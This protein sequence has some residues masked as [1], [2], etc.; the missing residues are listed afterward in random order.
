MS[1]LRNCGNFHSFLL[2][3][4]R[5]R[6]GGEPPGAKHSLPPARAGRVGAGAMKMARRLLWGLRRLQEGR[7]LPHETNTIGERLR[8]AR[9]EHPFTQEEL[10]ERSGVSRDL[11]AKLEQGRRQTARISSLAALADS[12]DIDLSDL[13]GKRPRLDQHDD[14]AHMHAVRDALLSPDHLPGIDETDDDGAP[15]SLEQLDVSLRHAWG[16]Y[17]SG[18]FAP[19]TAAMPGLIGEARITYRSAGAAAAGHLAQTY[20]L[21]AN[22]MV[23]L[24]RDDVAAISTERA[25]RAAAAGDDEL[26]WATLHSTYAWILLH[27]GR[28]AES[29]QHAAR[30]A[31]QIEP[32]ITKA[33]P[34]HL[35]VWGG[36]MLSAMASAAADP[37]RGDMAG[38]YISASRAAG[39]RLG[40]D[41]HDYWISFGPSQVAMQAT[42]AHAVLR[43]PAR[44]IAAA[45]DV[46]PDDLYR[47]SYGRHLVDVSQA[48]YE[49]RHPQAAVAALNTARDISP[50]W[51]RHQG[52]ARSL[53]ADLVET[54]RRLTPPL[55]SLARMMGVQ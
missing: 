11:I 35:V 10:A 47:V 43:E 25:L 2:C 21:A 14:G 33:A 8:R 15:T 20:Q 7:A 37:R 9:R 40:A 29:E 27:Q 45:R 41:R 6:E 13:V 30:I 17:W 48:H 46:R 4:A 55:R 42:H 53:V 38:E 24:G 18:R 51:F 22:L 26:Q 44:A 34:P 3:P 52:T 28:L 32:S 49:A 36:L 50:E 16:E 39:A 1:S 12:L 5:A 54:E 31:E 19:L 23:H